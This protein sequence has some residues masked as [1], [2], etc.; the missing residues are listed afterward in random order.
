MLTL[1]VNRGEPVVIRTQGPAEITVVSLREGTTR[2][3]V[4]AEREVTVNRASVQEAI[5]REMRRGGQA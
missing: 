1:R 2:L 4:E 5:D 3:G